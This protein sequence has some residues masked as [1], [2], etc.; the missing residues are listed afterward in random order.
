MQL[1][2]AGPLGDALRAA[3][4]CCR[5]ATP[6]TSFPA[7]LPVITACFFAPRCCAQ[8]ATPR[9]LLGPATPAASVSLTPQRPLCPP[10]LSPLW[11][12]SPAPPSHPPVARAL[13]PRLYGLLRRGVGLAT[14]STAAYMVDALCDKAP[15]VLRARLSTA[16]PTAAAAV[17]PAAAAATALGAPGGA[18][19]GGTR[20]SGGGGGGSGSGGGGGGGAGSGEAPARKFLFLLSNLAV[21]ERSPAIR[22]AF[23]QVTGT[24][25]APQ[26]CSLLRLGR[27]PVLAVVA[28]K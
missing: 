7:P 6:A 22:R 27:P 16:L 9:G 15:D 28:Q 12:V 11:L 3:L 20:S 17:V 2:R 24:T 18:G 10:H 5:C 4:D 8:P 25:P 21:T 14:R 1:A 26:P 13:V 19:P 23:C